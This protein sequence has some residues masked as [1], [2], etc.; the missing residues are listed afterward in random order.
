MGLVFNPFTGNF[1]FTGTGGGGGGT[2]SGTIEAGQIAIGVATDTIGPK[3][4]G[5]NINFVAGAGATY[6]FAD[7]G[8]KFNNTSGSE[9]GRIWFTDP[10]IAGNYFS[11]NIYIGLEAGKNATTNNTDSGYQNIGI[12][13]QALQSQTEGAYNVAIGHRSGASLTTSVNNLAIGAYSLEKLTTGGTNEGYNVGIGY[14]TM[15]QLLTGSG[16]TG[17]GASSMANALVTGVENTGIGL[18][19]L[20]YVTGSH[21]TAVGAGALSL[22]TSGSGNTMVGAIDDGFGAGNPP[23]TTG[24]N[25]SILGYLAGPSVNVSNSLSLGYQASPSASNTGVIGNASVTDVYFGSTSQAANVRFSAGFAKSSVTLGVAA[26]STGSAIFKGTTSGTVTLSVADAAG[27]WTMKL[28]TSAGTNTYLLQTDGSGNTSWV[29]PPSA[30][31]VVGT[32]AIASG[33]DTRILYDNAGILGEYT[34]TGTGTVVAMQTS[35]SL[36]TT[37]TLTRTSVGVTSA[38]GLIVTNTTAAAAGAQQY[39]P[40][41]RLT[42]QGWKTDATAASQT[43]DWIVENQPVQG[44]AAPTSKLV[45]SSQVNAGGFSTAAT[46]TSGGVLQVASAGSFTTPSLQVFTDGRGFYAANGGL[47]FSTSGVNPT[48]L[49]GYVA[50]TGIFEVRSN[51]TS[52]GFGLGTTGTG[53]GTGDLYLLR[54]SAAVLQMGQDI[55]GAAVSQTIQ[56]CNGIT[57]TDKTGGNLTVA[58]GKGTGAGAVSSLIFQTPTVLTTGTTAQSLATRLTIVEG[59]ITQS[60]GTNL[61]G[62]ANFHQ[63]TEMTA[64]AAGAANTVRIY[65]EDN[66][67]GKTRLMALFNTGAAQQIAIEP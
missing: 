34:L 44:A 16:N 28:P 63:M 65:A 15:S 29:A 10:D 33:T 12:G 64:P 45:F 53:T 49:W 24:D 59:S 52:V 13:Y 66:G 31:L 60:T 46:L 30:G 41:I 20:F 38:D 40:R 25:N 7:S 5:T 26:G 8:I 47:V 62:G 61:I 54:A 58:S 23:I 55:N 17:I 57:G 6:T 14:L 18:Y 36:L 3:F 27:T 2:I 42:G 48:N 37:V 67:A 35:P 9:T 1:D 56:A 39:S 43:V 11:G 4:T 32:T 21:N 50:A 51:A 19:T 22:V